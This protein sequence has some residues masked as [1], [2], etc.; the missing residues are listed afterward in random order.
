MS[1]MKAREEA[2]GRG[3]RERKEEYTE[4]NEEEPTM[5]QGRLALQ[6]TG[7]QRLTLE[8]HMQ[9][10]L[11]DALPVEEEGNGNR[12]GKA[13]VRRDQDQVERPNGMRL[14]RWSE[15]TT[16]NAPYTEASIWGK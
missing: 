5:R 10:N 15:E 16:N 12:K 2:E 13:E 4:V 7:S 11:G 9:N 8:P 1:N 6:S 14:G 3:E